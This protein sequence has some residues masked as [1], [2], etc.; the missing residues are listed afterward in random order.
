[1]PISRPQIE[2]PEKIYKNYCKFAPEL[3]HR[4]YMYK[5]LKRYTWNGTDG[6][7]HQYMYCRY[8]TASFES[9]IKTEKDPQGRFRTIRTIQPIQTDIIG[10]LM[11]SQDDLK[12]LELDETS[13]LQTPKINNKVV[14]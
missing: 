12:P 13:E 6:S 7:M 8:C 3:F 14:E 1:M 9:I 2:D 5:P 4:Y 10:P 11:P